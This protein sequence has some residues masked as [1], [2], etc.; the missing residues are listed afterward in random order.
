MTH[1]YEVGGGLLEGRAVPGRGRQ[2]EKNWDKSN[3]IINKIYLKK[4]NKVASSLNTTV[5][6]FQ[7]KSTDGY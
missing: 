4:K 2:R 5:A 6:I 1:G 3:S 7:I